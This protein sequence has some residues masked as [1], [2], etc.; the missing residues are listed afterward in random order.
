MSKE[1]KVAKERGW[2][3]IAGGIIL[4]IILG[5]AVSYYGTRPG[6]IVR[7]VSNL[8]IGIVVVVTE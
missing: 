5:I 2:R 4:G 1:E 6:A 7:H 8:L 3:F